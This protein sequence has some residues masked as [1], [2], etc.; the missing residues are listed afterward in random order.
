MWGSPGKSP[1]VGCRDVSPIEGVCFLGCTWGKRPAKSLGTRTWRALNALLS[2][3]ASPEG[4]GEPQKI[5]KQGTRSEPA[6]VWV[7]DQAGTHGTVQMNK[8]VVTIYYGTVNHLRV[9]CNVTFCCIF[10]FRVHSGAYPGSHQCTKLTGQDMGL[11]MFIQ[12]PISTILT[13]L[14]T[15]A[16]FSSEQ[17]ARFS[18]CSSKKMESSA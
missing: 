10:V 4:S 1:G 2:P 15:L 5:A 6:G 11:K 17:V 9:W 13:S 18:R 12:F 16:T 8:N 14:L 3:S 7:H